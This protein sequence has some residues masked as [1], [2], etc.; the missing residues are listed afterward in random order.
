[1]PDTALE[2]PFPAYG[3]AEP[4]IFVSYAHKDAAVVFPELQA[5]REAGYRVWFDEGIDPGNEWPEE[6]A[7]ALHRSSTFLVFISPAAVAS[8]NVRNEIHLAL[9]LD[10]DFLAVHLCDTDLPPGLQLSISSIQAILRH[11]MSPQNYWRKMVKVLPGTLRDAPASRQTPIEPQ[12]PHAAK[13]G[14]DAKPQESARRATEMEAARARVAAEKA[15]AEAE[16][17]AHAASALDGQAVDGAKVTCG[18]GS[19]ETPI[20]LSL[21]KGDSYNFKLTHTDTAGH[22]YAGELSIAAIWSGERTERVELSRTAVSTSFVRLGVPASPSR[23]T[24]TGKSSW[25]EAAAGMRRL[26]DLG[27]G[28]RLELCGIPSGK[29]TMGGPGSDETPHAVTLT[30]AFWLG[31]TQVT[32]AQWDAVFR[33]NSSSFKGRDLPVE[34][35]NWDFAMEFCERLNAKA[36]LP[37]GWKFALPSEAQW[38]YACR[39]GIAKDSAGSLN[40]LAWFA[41]NSGGTTHPVATKKPNDWGLHDMCG[42]VWEWCADWYGDYPKGAVT[43]PTGP[44]TGSNRVCRGGAWNGGREAC[45]PANR[46]GRTPSFYCDYVGF[47]V[48]SVPGGG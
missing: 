2:P 32:Q 6:I 42:N 26:V 36:L 47:R 39:S 24:P 34:G 15:K 37:V 38:E 28:V 4:F 33:H 17:K 29:F 21:G 10:K 19:W 12:P 40:E 31:R 46:N 7:N 8:R 11:Q 25:D 1:M 44:N 48:A 18:D 3:G 35:V 41:G 14:A 5:L 43:D 16:A 9:R 23:D 13:G 27:G 22:M 20:G 30:N 45:R